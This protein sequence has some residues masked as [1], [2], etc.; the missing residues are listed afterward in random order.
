[1]Y[2]NMRIANKRGMEFAIGTIAKLLL[3]LVGLALALYL[4]VGPNSIN[5]LL[6]SWT[7]AF[8]EKATVY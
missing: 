6:E 8:L 5:T 1:M 4:L 3:L 2:G 7:G